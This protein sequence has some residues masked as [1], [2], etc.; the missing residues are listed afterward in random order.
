ME[1]LEAMGVPNVSI[2]GLIAQARELAELKQSLGIPQFAQAL[3]S[4]P[5]EHRVVAGSVGAPPVL[6]RE[7]PKSASAAAAVRYKVADDNQVLEDTLKP[8]AA[9][10]DAA[11][12][13]LRPITPSRTLKD[14]L[15]FSRWRVARSKVT[16]QLFKKQ[17]IAEIVDEA[18]RRKEQLRRGQLRER[19]IVL[20]PKS[21]PLTPLSPKRLVLKKAATASLAVTR[22]KL[23]SQAPS[24]H[25]MNPRSKMAADTFDTVHRKRV[26]AAHVS[27]TRSASEGRFANDPSSR[28]FNARL[29]D[30]RHNRYFVADK[31]TKAKT[32]NTGPIVVAQKEVYVNTI[33]AVWTIS[34]SIFGKRAHSLLFQGRS[35]YFDTEEKLLKCIDLDWSLALETH[36]TDIY[37]DQMGGPD[38]ANAILNVFRQHNQAVYS[39]YDFYCTLGKSDDICHMWKPAF[40]R[41][42][43]D[44]SFED[45]DS[46]TRGP[47]DIAKL[48][49]LLNSEPTESQNFINRCE[50]LQCLVRLAS[51]K[52]LPAEQQTGLASAVPGSVAEALRKFITHDMM[53]R[54]DRRSLADTNLFRENM[55]YVEDVDV[56]LKQWDPSLRAIFN[57][58]AYGDGTMDDI[59]S[60]E[61]MSYEEWC[62]FVL[63]MELYD[64]IDFT[65]REASLT[66]VWARLREID[67]RPTKAKSRM[68]QL[69]FEE[70]LEA[71]IRVASL[72]V[73]P[74]DDEVE[75]AGCEDAGELM[76]HLLDQPKAER[77]ARL[78]AHLCDWD[79]PLVQPIFHLLEGLIQYLVRVVSGGEKRV[80]AGIARRYKEEWDQGNKREKLKRS[81]QGIFT[82]KKVEPIDPNKEKSEEQKVMASLFGCVNGGKPLQDGTDPSWN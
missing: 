6:P 70:F 29:R 80:T 39:I 36:T 8:L 14:S 38:E 5:R 32:Y 62:N 73:I 17:S 65:S 41:F 49:K 64:A 27:L 42:G 25:T 79:D 58:Y 78:Q 48:W 71:L 76:S 3:P 63:D 56:V 61:M 30:V 19:N 9:E 26:A 60:T 35:G 24:W 31:L 50:W 22:P 13:D 68:M 45:K 23:A 59:F 11:R 69:S 1:G 21:P 43:K 34:K 67:E 10:E 51:M 55:C 15:A 75:E 57:A 72:K 18:L 53:T 81:L 44:L 46:K 4:P 7:L 82:Q 66:F 16:T 77:D 20:A 52:Y 40:T 74:L 54:V 37:L 12:A 2:E 28:E 47:N 33:A